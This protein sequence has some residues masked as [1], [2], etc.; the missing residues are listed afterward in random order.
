MNKQEL[1]ESIENLNKLYRERKYV[2]IDD[3]LSLVNKL[4]ESEKVKVP[5]FVAEWYEKHKKNLDYEIWDYF[6]EWSSQKQDDFYNW[7]NNSKECIVTL[8]NM[9]Q[10][11]YEVE[12]EKKYRVKLK[13]NSEYVDY[14]VDTGSTGFRFFNNIYTKNREHTRKELEE[15]NFGWVFDCEGVEVEEVEE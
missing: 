12:K 15:A 5:K 6:R 13:N 3:I 1:I 2:A 4:D 10:F 7:V 9:H 14:L 11:G 8:S